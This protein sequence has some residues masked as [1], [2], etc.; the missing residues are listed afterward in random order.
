VIELP[1]PLQH[2]IRQ[3]LHHYPSQH[4]SD[5]AQLLS[6]RYRAPR[7]G[8]ALVTSALDA[9]AYTAILMPATYAQLARVFRMCAPHVDGTH[10]RSMLDIGSGPGT[11]LWAAHAYMPNLTIRT[12]VERDP[13][14]VGLAQQLCQP[15]DG[16]TTFIQQDITHNPC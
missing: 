3:A 2:L 9:L 7:D 1:A 12:A 6:E 13:H 10:W 8:S 15:L 16:Q 11:A 5:A 4:W 14:F